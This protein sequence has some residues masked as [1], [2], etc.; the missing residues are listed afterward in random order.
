M[1]QDKI[2]SLKPGRDLDIKV[3]LEVMDYI[4][5][6]HLLQF[7]AELAVKWLGTVADM[8][9]A[10]GMYVKVPE[11]QFVGLKEREDFAEAVLPFS[12]D[13]A[14][15]EKIFYHM[16]KQGYECKLENK[17]EDGS[18]CYYASIYR[19]GTAIDEN[20]VG[21]TTAP[22]AIVKAALKAVQIG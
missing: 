21:F 4:W 16:E 22:E 2:V 13:L 11:E 5:L 9:A 12:T 14:A 6:K 1:N 3:A 10:G 20:L 17:L 8:E 7:S 15:A 18:N 19:P